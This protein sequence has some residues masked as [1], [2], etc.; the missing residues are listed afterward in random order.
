MLSLKDNLAASVYREAE[1]YELQ[2]SMFA[3]PNTFTH[4]ATTYDGH[5]MRVYMDG[6]LVSQG[7][8]GPIAGNPSSPTIVIGDSLVSSL[9]NGFPSFLFNGVIHEVRIWNCARTPEQV[10]TFAKV[11]LFGTEENLVGYWPLKGPVEAGC[12]TRFV[13]AELLRD[14]AVCGRTPQHALR[15]DKGVEW[16]SWPASTIPVQPRCSSDHVYFSGAACHL[17]NSRHVQL[18]RPR[19]E[20][21]EHCTSSVWFKRGVRLSE[22]FEVSASLVLA[23]AQAKGG[24]ALLV[25]VGSLASSAR[26]SKSGYGYDGLGRVLAVE[27]VWMENTSLRVRV[28]RTAKEGIP[29]E[30]VCAVP[31]K[32]DLISQ[33][34]SVITVKYQGR[35]L[36][37]SINKETVLTRAEL[38]L[39]LVFSGSTE[40]CH[41][42]SQATGPKAM[43]L[44]TALHHITS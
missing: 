34:T 7:A 25:K 19:P 6:K 16:I 1:P 18:V 24:F 9:T 36:T 5:T 21:F 40:A 31:V 12:Q 32:L 17:P 20:K 35:A 29:T 2:S 26:L 11:S 14:V 44:Y 39:P 4:I 33:A 27:F 23:Q 8:Y 37:V 15:S 41:G 13:Q 28:V 38:S 43:V 10:A 3:Q 42:S 22:H 30:L